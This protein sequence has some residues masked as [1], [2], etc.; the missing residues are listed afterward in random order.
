MRCFNCYSEFAPTLS[1]P[2]CQECGFCYYCRDFFSCIHYDADNKDQNK[3]Q[4]QQEE[5]QQ[6]SQSPWENK[7]KNDIQNWDSYTE[8]I[9]SATLTTTP[10]DPENST[11]VL[12]IDESLRRKLGKLHILELIQKLTSPEMNCYVDIIPTGTSDNEVI[13][14]F[15]SYVN[16]PALIV[17]SDKGLYE[18]L[19][20]NSL[21]IKTKKGSNAVR[22][23][24]QAIRHRISRL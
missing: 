9:S 3:K 19:P 13:K 14:V 23:I 17:T 7:K 4:K 16:I 10:P 21:F 18:R 22:V 11:A 6:L 5:Q 2:L 1:K 24:T 15:N 8:L 20:A 12:V